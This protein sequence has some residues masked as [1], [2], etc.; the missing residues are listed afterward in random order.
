MIQGIPMNRML[1]IVTGRKTS[2]IGSG[3]GAA[4]ARLQR[5]QL[6]VDLL[7]R[8]Q[9]G[10]L[11]FGPAIVRAADARTSTRVSSISRMIMRIILAGSSALSSRSVKLAAMMS[12]VREKMPMSILL[13]DTKRSKKEVAGAGQGGHAPAL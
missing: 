3:L 8:A 1:Q 5:G 7:A 2:S 12:R 11:S 10:D 6:C 4:D 13:K 9:L